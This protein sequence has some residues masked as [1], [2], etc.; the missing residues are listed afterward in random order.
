[1]LVREYVRI[2]HEVSWR[3]IQ[4]ELGDLEALLSWAV[5][6]AGEAEASDARA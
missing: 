4:G 3:A 6:K 1:V 5:R 2:D